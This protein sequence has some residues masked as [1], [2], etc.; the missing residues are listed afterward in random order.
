[1]I[2]LPAAQVLLSL[3]HAQKSIKVIF[4]VENAGITARAQHMTEPQSTT[5]L[6]VYSARC[7]GLRWGAGGQQLVG[8][9]L[10]L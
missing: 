6:L 7:M 4:T 1:M 9:P 10:N 3:S 5:E 2:V 8:V